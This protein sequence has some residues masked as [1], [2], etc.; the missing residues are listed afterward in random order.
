[1]RPQISGTNLTPKAFGKA[2]DPSPLNGLLSAVGTS[3][4]ARALGCKP[5]AV[6][7]WR[8]RRVPA[9]REAAL[10]AWAKRLD[11]PE[12]EAWLRENAAEKRHKRR[13]RAYVDAARLYSLKGWWPI[14]RA[15]GAPQREPVEPPQWLTDEQI[16][17][18]NTFLDMRPR[19]GWR[20][21]RGEAAIGLVRCL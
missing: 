6:R 17:K 20:V 9:A 11:M 21:I 8:Q 3:A 10:I 18:V 5:R 12:L 7:Q 19:P 16:A 4:V 1:M 2:C 14:S 13:A 15:V